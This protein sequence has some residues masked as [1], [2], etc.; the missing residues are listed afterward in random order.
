MALQ[1]SQEQ[2]KNE[3]FGC[4]TTNIVERDDDL[5]DSESDL[6]DLVE[7]IEFRSVSNHYQK[8]LK[9]KIDAIKTETKII[10]PADKTANFYKIEKE[11][12]NNLVEKNVHKEYRKAKKNEVT[13]GIKEHQ[14]IVKNLSIDDRVFATQKKNCFVSLKDH[15]PNFI[16]N[17]S[18]RHINPCK[19]EIR[20]ISKQSL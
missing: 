8:E 1:K 18:C 9:T 7:N 3:T 12:Y 11:E 17:P 16:N 20:N 13:K 10:V 2:G 5:K 15:K 14:K 19:P 4:P 6:Y